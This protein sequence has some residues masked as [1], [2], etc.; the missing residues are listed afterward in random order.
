VGA[1]VAKGV[2]FQDADGR[3]DRDRT[4]YEDAE[5]ELEAGATGDRGLGA[6]P[7]TGRFL[8]RGNAGG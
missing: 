1:L 7:P 3:G 2:G 6:P 4:H 5:E 8:I